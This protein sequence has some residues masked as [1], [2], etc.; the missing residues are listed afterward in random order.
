MAD[1]T[2]KGASGSTKLV[3]SDLDGNETNYLEVKGN[4]KAQ[5]ET[6][7]DTVNQVIIE[8]SG[9]GVTAYLNLADSSTGNL[10]GR[11]GVR[12]LN[13]GGKIRWRLSP[14]LSGINGEDIGKNE[15]VEFNYSDNILIEVIERNNNNEIDIIVTEF[16]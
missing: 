4:S 3:G 5:T 10:S 7:Y 2:E 9:N 16:K 8:K 12:I 6:V 11:S 1:I 15:V 13:R 14:D